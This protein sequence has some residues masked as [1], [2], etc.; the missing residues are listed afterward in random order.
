MTA[1]KNTDSEVA[2]TVTGTNVESSYDQDTFDADGTRNVVGVEVNIEL[3]TSGEATYT[4]VQTN[5]GLATYYSDDTNVVGNVK[6]KD[7]TES[8]L[9]DG[10]SFLVTDTSG[11]IKIEFYKDGTLVKTYTFTN[12]VTFA[13]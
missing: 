10:Y 7:Y 2:V 4:V 12:S 1:T 6:T 9:A 11:D 5:P 3:P 13:S 8:D